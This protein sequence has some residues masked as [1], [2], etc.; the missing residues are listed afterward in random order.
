MRDKLDKFFELCAI[1]IV[2]YCFFKV[3]FL[4][5]GFNYVILGSLWLVVLDQAKILRKLK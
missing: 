5:G 3:A 1:A 4:D 2:I